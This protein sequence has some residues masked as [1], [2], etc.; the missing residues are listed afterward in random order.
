MFNLAVPTSKEDSMMD[1]APQSQIPD[2]TALE[3]H[4]HADSL[5]MSG[6]LIN[7]KTNSL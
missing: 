4:M 6:Y 3:H 2:S 5:P 1:S 7:W